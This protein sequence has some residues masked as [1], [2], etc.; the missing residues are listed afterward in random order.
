MK[1]TTPQ[2]KALK[3]STKPF[4]NLAPLDQGDILRLRNLMGNPRGVEC[5]A[6]IPALPQPKRS[7]R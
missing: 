3:R 4:F 1:T 7:K 2:A 6:A 5:T